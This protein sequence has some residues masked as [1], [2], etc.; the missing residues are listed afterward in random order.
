M[1]TI[2][3]SP[4]T[5][6]AWTAQLKDGENTIGRS[7]DNDI[8][9]GEDGVSG[10]HC[11]VTV[12]G[13]SVTITDLNSTNGTLVDGNRIHQLGWTAGAVI[14]LGPI[15]ARLNPHLSE[16]SASPVSPANAAR[17]AV[18]VRVANAAPAAAGAGPTGTALAPL[19]PE[20]ASK[21]RISLRLSGHA[22]AAAVAPAPEPEV[23]SHSPHSPHSPEMTA[24][25]AGEAP[26]A[27]AV[28]FAPAGTNCKSHHQIPASWLCP[29]CHKYFC[30]LCVSTRATSAGSSHLCRGCGIECTRVQV[31]AAEETAES[32]FFGRLP[33]AFLYPIRG[34]GV[35]ILIFATVI[36]EGSSMLAGLFSIILKMAI[37]GYLFV[38]MQDIIHGTAVGEEKMPGLPEFDGLFAA[39]FKLLGTVLVSFIIPIGLFIAKFSDV[40]IPTSAFIASVFVS[41]LYFPMAFLAVAILDSVA[42]ANPL[43]VIPSILRVPGQYV[44]AVLI[45]FAV[46]GVRLLGSNLMEDAKGVTFTTTEMSVLFLSLGGRMLWSLFS[47]YL[48]TVSVRILGLLYLTQKHKLGW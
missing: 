24:E 26:A 28:F 13:A 21:P 38:F 8:C 43:V 5:P 1:V 39:F 42:A 18:A 45:I 34:I 22:P 20:V 6:G 40:E 3:F 25:M 46:Y 31:E 11:R 23:N 9:V 33:G 27:P 4:D 10:H 44:V 15:A 41:L 32:G 2:T 48:M 16:P 12:N 35:F 37:T 47:V 14:H 36:F 17:P 30:D 7:A 19:E 29:K